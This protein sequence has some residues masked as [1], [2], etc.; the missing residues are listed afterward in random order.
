MAA[1]SIL[2]CLALAVL[3]LANPNTLQD[4]YGTPNTENLPSNFDNSPD[5]TSLLTDGA[6]SAQ[7]SATNFGSAAKVGRPGPVGG[8]VE[9]AVGSGAQSSGQGAPFVAEAQSFSQGAGFVDGS[10][11]QSSGQGADFAVGSG[12]QSSGQGAG[13]AVG[14]GAQSSG[15][16]AGF[17][18]GSGAQSSGQ[19]AG[20][21]VGAG[22]QSS[23]Q[24]VGDRS[25]SGRQTGITGSQLS[26]SAAQQLGDQFAEAASFNREDVTI[27]IE[28][29]VD[30]FETLTNLVYNS[31]PVTLTEFVKT[32]LIRPTLQI[33]TTPVDDNV[34]V[35]TVPAFR[36]EFVTVTDTSSSFQCATEVSTDSFTITHLAHDIRQQ[37]VTSTVVQ[38]EIFRPTVVSTRIFTETDTATVFQTVTNTVIVDA[39]SGNLFASAFQTFRP[40]SGPLTTRGYAAG[41]GY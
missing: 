34:F 25:F 28:N 23:G 12:A 21:S 29:T 19:G 26:G 32:T 33:I 35:T 2:K 6:S 18:V 10:G 30:V 20:F 7:N 11:A 16:G 9:F 41:H 17:A 31:V 39:N 22:A 14:S 13:F 37:I 5:I 8:N 36:T 24:G 1:A 3:V 27:T 4:R 38:T 15:Q 40:V